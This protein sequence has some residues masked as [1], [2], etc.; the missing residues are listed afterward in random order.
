MASQTTTVSFVAHPDDDLLFMN[1]DIASDIQAGFDVWVVYL[2]AGDVPLRPGKSHGGMD[3]VDMRI[4][5]ARAAYAR[6]ARSP[7]SWVFE[8]MEFGDHVVVT[9]R[10]EDANVRLVFTFIHAASGPE[11]N[12]GDLYRL[13]NDPDFTAD[14]IDGRPGYTRA[15]IGTMIRGVLDT[16]QPSYIRTLSTLGHHEGDHIDHT[17]AALLVAEA[18]RDEDGFTLVQ[19]DEYIGYLASREESLWD[20]N[21]FGFW[22]DEKIAIWNEYWPRDPELFA[23]AWFRAMARQY[24]LDD[25]TDPPGNVW[26]PPTDFVD[27]C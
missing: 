1:P 6:A 21:V 11:D 18:N 3:Y 2:T 20:E 10:L 8:E 15:S 19:R 7:N 12:C 17:A 14:P 5:G 16:A 27:L 9:N 26:E 22:L 24:L 23:G 25:R 4:N 13:W